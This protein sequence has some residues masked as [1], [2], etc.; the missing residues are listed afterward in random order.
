[1]QTIWFMVCTP[2]EGLRTTKTSVQIGMRLSERLAHVEKMIEC[3]RHKQL[4][5]CDLTVHN[6]AVNRVSMD[7]GGAPRIALI[8]CRVSMDLVDA[9]RIAL[10]GCR[11]SNWLS[12]GG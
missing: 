4:C 3:A 1:M 6:M 10:I 5:G 9:P 11:V 12:N 7:L 8:G 2:D